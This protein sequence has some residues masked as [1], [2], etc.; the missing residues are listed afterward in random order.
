MDEFDYQIIVELYNKKIITTV[1][2]DFYVSQ[3]ALTKRLKK[4]EE[5]CGT[6]LF[7]RTKK[8]V[9]F[10]E[11]GK[12][13]YEYCKKN[14]ENKE[15]LFKA[16]SDTKQTNKTLEIGCSTAF[17]LC[18]L[19]KLIDEFTIKHKDSELHIHSE[20]SYKIYQQLLNGDL[21]I[22]IIRDDYAWEGAKI[23]IAEEPVCLIYNKEVSHKDLSN[24][25]AITYTSSP[26][27]EKKMNKWMKEN[28]VTLA[29][30]TYST[31][32]ITSAY[33]LV[34]QGVGWSIMPSI[35]FDDFDGYIEELTVNNE[36]YTRVTY[37]YYNR[38]CEN[39]K[40]SADFINFVL[41]QYKT[42]KNTKI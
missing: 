4:I 24:I 28:N 41:N 19:P 7:N 33:N 35:I 29:N 23:K 40:N 18:K 34:K 31:N 30:G 25:P 5:E 39:Y 14:L 8:G 15:E 21:D 12:L 1:A 16:F 26:N 9:T 6:T 32:D 13:L 38:E 11:H 3:P 2:N 17:A 20:Q 42:Y 27:L 10:T 22:A 37:L 36:D